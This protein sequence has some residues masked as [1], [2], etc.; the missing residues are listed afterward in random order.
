MKFSSA[1]ALLATFTAG[2]SAFA[3]HHASTTTT[4][5]TTTALSAIGRRDMLASAAAAA[6]WILPQAAL[7]VEKREVY[8]TE[9]TAE[10]KENEEKAMAFKREQ[11]KLKKEF[12]QVMERF[13]SEPNDETV[14]INDLKEFQSLVVKTRGLPVGLKKDELFKVIRSKK[15]KGYWPTAVEIA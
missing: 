8:L 3:P 13:P 15:A 12:Q 5:T 6:M 9:P 7:A 10:F 4:T 11:L 2:A 1:I 14:L